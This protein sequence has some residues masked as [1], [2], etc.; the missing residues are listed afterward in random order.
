MS[1][2]IRKTT[3]ASLFDI[4]FIV[5]EQVQDLFSTIRLCFYRV[6]ELRCR[7]A[8]PTETRSVVYCIR[9]LRQH[10]VHAFS[11]RPSNSTDF[12]ERVDSICRAICSEYG[13][14]E[15]QTQGLCSL[16]LPFSRDFRIGYTTLRACVRVNI[17]IYVYRRKQYGNKKETRK[18]KMVT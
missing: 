8:A 12:P 5:A 14:A 13:I 2:R 16:S 1:Y 11:S 6:L 18:R 9:R 10:L 15:T 3:G 17:Y 4:Y 7:D